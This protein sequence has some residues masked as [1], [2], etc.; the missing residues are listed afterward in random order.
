MEKEEVEVEEVEEET[1]PADEF[2]E[3]QLER[4]RTDVN[5]KIN[6]SKD[7]PPLYHRKTLDMNK[8]RGDI[9]RDRRAQR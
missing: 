2:V 4:A 1:R 9:D 3:V 6:Q 7:P 5:I 8:R